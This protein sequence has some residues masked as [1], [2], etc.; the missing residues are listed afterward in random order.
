MRIETRCCQQAL[1]N[2]HCLNKKYQWV[3]LK[4]IVKVTSDVHEKSTGKETTETRWYISSLELNA[5]HALFSVRNHWQVESL[6]WMLDMTF[7]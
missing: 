7:R 4:I 6:H 3:G 2:K 5:E 1:V